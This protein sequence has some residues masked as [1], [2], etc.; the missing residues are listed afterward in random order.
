MDTTLPR[1]T[2]IP[3]GRWWPIGLLGV[4][5]LAAAAYLPNLEASGYGNSYY[6]AAAWAGS[7]N[8]PAWFFGAWDPANFITVDKPPLATMV[9][10]ISVRLLGLSPLSVMLPQALAGILATALLFLVVRRSFGTVAGTIAAVVMALTPVA[11]LIFRYDNP[12]ALLTL[13]LIAAAGCLVRGLEDGGLRWVVGA[14][15]LAGLGFTTKFLQ[16]DLAVPGLALAWLVAAPGSRRRRLGQLAVAGIALA[17]SSLWWVAAVELTPA[18]SRPYVGGSAGNSALELLFGYNGLGRLLHTG[19]SGALVAN[20]GGSGAAGTPGPFRLLGVDFGGQIAWL[21]PFALVGLAAGLVATR[22]R[23]GQRRRFGAYVL[24]G[25]WLA[26]HVLVFSFMTGMIHAYYAVAAAPAVAA[27]TGG[28]AVDLWGRRRGWASRLAG[29]PLAAAVLLSA[30]LAWVLL[31]RTPAFLPGLGPAVLLLGIGA[32]LVFGVPARTPSLVQLG[33]AALAS[34]ALLAGPA[35]YTAA[36]V[37]GVYSG[38]NPSAGPRVE[39]AAGRGGSAAPDQGAPSATLGFSSHGQDRVPDATLLAYLEANRGDATWIVAVTSADD[40]G[41]LELET[42]APVMAMGGFKGNDPA[43]TVAQLQSLTSSGRLR[44]V[45][46][47]TATAGESAARDAWV[48]SACRQVDFG[49]GLEGSRLYDC[50][51]TANGTAP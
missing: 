18:A 36:T 11:A 43:P 22:S 31:G 4:T 48:E 40:D 49:L 15:V 42:Q 13:L 24:W 14:A 38:G 46:A 27:L 19:T 32:A 17:V 37:H 25:T 2:T 21:F 8:P 33:G 50:A 28:G 6:A 34:V 47:G 29:L 5:A 41:P 20:A 44:F 10:A 16:A 3:S 30:V 12:D 35:A 45:I 7:V 1:E 23:R 51:A 26:V 9:M 39:A